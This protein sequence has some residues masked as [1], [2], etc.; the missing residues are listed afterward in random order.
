[1]LLLGGLWLVAAG[2]SDGIATFTLVADG[3]EATGQVLRLEPGPEGAGVVTVIGMR[4]PDQS[5]I[6]L[7]DGPHP[8]AE[9]AV[10][11]PVRLIL[12][13][14]QPEQARINELAALWSGPVFRVLGGLGA[15]AV[16][17]AMM[18]TAGPDRQSRM[19]VPLAL[20]VALFGLAA[21]ATAV[22]WEN[23]SGVVDSLNRFPRGE[24][25][26]IA[27]EAGRPRVLF[28]TGDAVTVEFVDL[29]APAGRYAVDDHVV[30]GYAKAA[31]S[32][33]RIERFE[34]VWGGAT[35][36]GAVAGLCIL[37]FLYASTWRRRIVPPPEQ[38]ASPAPGPARGPHLFA[39]AVHWGGDSWRRLRRERQ[40]IQR[41]PGAGDIELR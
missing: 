2:L 30:V 8:L 22:A 28:V 27:L 19:R 23:Y 10:G 31:P 14:G 15:I 34:E 29:N 1:M 40:A 5:P 12:P 17:I 36:W 24:G 16:G 39:R 21:G 41:V 18:L 6:E 37:V 32:G 9:R 35:R 38:A 33:A 11:A 4:R 7:R 20:R 3:E 25:R 13:R 26:V